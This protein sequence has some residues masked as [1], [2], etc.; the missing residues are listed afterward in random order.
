V[1]IF[2]FFYVRLHTVY[3]CKTGSVI[4]LQ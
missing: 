3:S 4:S 2:T 1:Y